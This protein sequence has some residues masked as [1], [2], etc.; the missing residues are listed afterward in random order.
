MP[1]NSTH[2][3]PET[4][5]SF[6]LDNCSEMHDS[7]SMCNNSKKTDWNSRHLDITG[8]AVDIVCITKIRLIQPCKNTIWFATGVVKE[9]CVNC[10]QLGELVLLP[11]KFI[12]V[13]VSTLLLTRFFNCTKKSLKNTPGDD[14]VWIAR[15]VGTLL[16]K[17][18][19]S[20]ETLLKR[21]FL[22]WEVTELKRECVLS[23]RGKTMRVA[24][25]L[26]NS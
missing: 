24:E 19:V 25:R 14:L 2:G 6:V 3:Y 1:F 15:F 18:W 20:P 11:G 8:S 17:V 5:S 23:E 13:K 22:N 7:S 9:P 21:I 16:R 4:S 26:Q 12:L 10:F